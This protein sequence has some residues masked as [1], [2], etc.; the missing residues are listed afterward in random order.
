MQ[1]T[2][3]DQRILIFKDQIS[4]EYAKA[5]AW[6][7]KVDAFGNIQKL[8][9]FLSR[10][11]DEE[12][13]IT[14]SEHRYQPIWHIKGAFKY[15]YERKTNYDVPVG[16]PE[17]K[18]VMIEGKEYSAIKQKIVL[19]GL[20]HCIEEE[21]LEVMVDG[22]SGVK[23][24]ALTR[25]LSYI[26]SITDK[27]ELD[28]LSADNIIIVPPQARVSALV[29]EILASA[30]KV[31][32]ADK[33]YEERIDISNVDLYYRPVYAFQ[34]DWKTKQKQ[35]VVEVDGLSSEVT[36]GNKTFQ[37]YLGKQV[38]M[39]FLFDLG[40]DAAGM[41]LP[42]GSIAVKLAKKYIESQKK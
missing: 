13:E 24:S 35:M 4:L 16:G 22:I 33:V 28:Q 6:S 9:N 1:T 11:K 37:E 34:I 40:A 10:P 14:Y 21:Q 5:T 31:I 29:N 23:Q 42:G 27:A 19:E 32:H 26:A 38:D 2:I 20:D 17:V 41:I 30:V 15:D 12:F 18:T 36:F 39:N 25:Y 8:T 3:A 7:K